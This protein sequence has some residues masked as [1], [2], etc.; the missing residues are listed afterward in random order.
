MRQYELTVKLTG[1]PER[2]FMALYRCGDIRVTQ[3]RLDGVARVPYGGVL[4]EPDVGGTIKV[5]APKK[6]TTKAKAKK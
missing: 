5:P 4:A 3:A 6:R 2:A 1:D